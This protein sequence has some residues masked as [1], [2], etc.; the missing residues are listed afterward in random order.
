MEKAVC[1]LY[2]C[3]C[4]ATKFGFAQMCDSCYANITKELR[5]QIAQEI[6][7]LQV[8][9]TTRMDGATWWHEAEQVKAKC[10]AIAKG[11]EAEPTKTYL[12]T[13]QFI[14]V[15]KS[16]DDG[17]CKQLNDTWDA[18]RY[19]TRYATRYTTRDAA[20]YAIWYA[21][22]YTDLAIVVRDKITDEQFKILT[23]PWTSCGLSLY[24]EDWQEVLNPKVEAPCST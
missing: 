13:E 14:K 5:D 2:G 17:K 8:S 3:G 11:V 19:A 16:L 15:W 20:W 10:I 18:A 6:E 9:G 21:A 22:R 4:E 23:S 12:T 7:A 1:E 24:S